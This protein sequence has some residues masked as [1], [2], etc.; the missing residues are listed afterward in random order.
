MEDIS[1]KIHINFSSEAAFKISYDEKYTNIS[2]SDPLIKDTNDINGN[3]IGVSVGGTKSFDIYYTDPYYYGDVFVFIPEFSI[4]AD[5]DKTNFIPIVECVK[6]TKPTVVFTFP[7]QSKYDNGVWIDIKFINFPTGIVPLNIT[8]GMSVSIEATSNSKNLFYHNNDLCFVSPNL[9]GTYYERVFLKPTGD[10]CDTF[11]LTPDKS[12]VTKITIDSTHDLCIIG[13]PVTYKIMC[14]ILNMT[15]DPLDGIYKANIPCIQLSD[16]LFKYN[17]SSQGTPTYSV[18]DVNPVPFS[19]SFTVTGGEVRKVGDVPN[20]TYA[21]C[22]NVTCDGMPESMKS[23][24]TVCVCDILDPKFLP[25]DPCMPMRCFGININYYC[26]GGDCNCISYVFGSDGITSMVE[27]F[28]L[29]LQIIDSIVQNTIRLDFMTTIPDIIPL[30]KALMSS[31]ETNYATLIKSKFD[32]ITI[33]EPD[34]RLELKLNH[35]IEITFNFFRSILINFVTKPSKCGR[36]YDL[37]SKVLK[38]NAEA[39]VF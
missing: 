30:S 23:K 15:L 28:G 17:V 20:G 3:T 7:D 2:L 4:L 35:F 32:G 24:L 37:S 27:L 19:G 18:P 6:K 36:I 26:P 25:E 21:I 14:S 33:I 22:I 1:D 9:Y 34:S 16:L 39:R 31:S 13:D 11:T 29:M 8:T 5:G 12:I 38:F 10:Y